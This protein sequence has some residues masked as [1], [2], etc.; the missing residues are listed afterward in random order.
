MAEE[1]AKKTLNLVIKSDV[2]G[3][4]EAIIASLAK[5][6]HEEVAVHVIG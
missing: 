4:L 1:Q 2:L 3:S 5:I 6:V